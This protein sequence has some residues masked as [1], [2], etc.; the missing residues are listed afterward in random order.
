MIGRVQ[1]A[2]PRQAHLSAVGMAGEDEV[3]AGVTIVLE[4]FGP[5]GEQQREAVWGNQ[6]GG[7][8]AG[9]EGGIVQSGDPQGRA[10]ALNRFHFIPQDV[11]A[12]FG[13]LRFERFKGV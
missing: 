11:H 13:E 5:V 4:Q 3:G 12:C 9:G 1:S 8:C 6:T 2:E 7:I 10:A